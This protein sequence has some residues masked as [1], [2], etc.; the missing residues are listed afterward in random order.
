MDIS[1]KIKEYFEHACFKND[2][3]LNIIKDTNI[4]KD[5]YK[6]VVVPISK[7]SVSD[8]RH[9]LSR[10]YKKYTTYDETSIPIIISKL[11]GYDKKSITNYIEVVS[12][13]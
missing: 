9:I 4:Q 2:V 3:L 13:R 8:I 6:D 11:K 10:F 12:K 1:D 5:E 7:Y